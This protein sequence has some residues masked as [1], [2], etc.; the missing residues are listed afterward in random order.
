VAE[1]NW[2]DEERKGKGGPVQRKSLNVTHVLHL[3]TVGMKGGGKKSGYKGGETPAKRKGSYYSQKRRSN[4][5]ERRGEKFNLEE[6]K[7]LKGF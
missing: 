4:V 5:E 3:E 2:Q 1:K 6:E 7:A